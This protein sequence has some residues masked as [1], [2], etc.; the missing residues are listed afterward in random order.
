MD[1]SSNSLRLRRQSDRVAVRAGTVPIFVRRKWDCPPWRDYSPRLPGEGAGGEGGHG[2][3]SHGRDHG[4][5]LT[6][7]GTVVWPL[8]DNLGTIRDL[9]V[10]ENGVTNA[11]NH[12]AYDSYGNLKSQTGAVDCLFGFTGRAFDSNTGLQNNLNRWYDA[13]KW[14]VDGKN[15][16]HKDARPL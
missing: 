6:Q 14:A 2:S 3:G 5:D 11:V 8:G 12:R 4:H 1:Q 7:P 16:Q 15:H 10:A 9:A 13:S